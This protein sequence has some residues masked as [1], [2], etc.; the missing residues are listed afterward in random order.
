MFSCELCGTIFDSNVAEVDRTCPGCGSD[1][2][3]H[4]SCGFL[5]VTGG[6]EYGDE[7]D[8]YYDE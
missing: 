6:N 3:N 8:S 1:Y 7:Y 2:R 5:P 4:I